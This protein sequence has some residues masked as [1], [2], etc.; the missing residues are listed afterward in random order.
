MPNHKIDTTTRTIIAYLINLPIKLELFLNR[1]LTVNT[2][3]CIEIK[4]IQTIMLPIGI[5]NIFFVKTVDPIENRII[6]I[7]M[8]KS[9]IRSDI[10]LFMRQNQIF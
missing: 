10:L 3:N 1:L 7:N 5:S 4:P 6:I 8:I 2:N 9:K